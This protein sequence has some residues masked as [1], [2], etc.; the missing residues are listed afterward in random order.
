MRVVITG[1][2]GFLGR[3]VAEAFVQQGCEVAAIVRHTSRTGPLE[4]LGVRLHTVTFDQPEALMQ[5]VTGAEAIVHAAAKVH[6]Y[7]RWREFQHVTVEGT[8]ALLNAVAR[9]RV[10]HFI[11]LSTVGVYGWPRPDGRPFDETCIFGKP[12]RWNY[13]SRAKILAEQFVQQSPTPFT[14]LRPTWVY[15]PQDT[16]SIPRIVNA[17]RAGRLKLIGDGN[18]R[19]SIVYVTD[20]ARAVVAIA[21]NPKTRGAIFNIANDETCPTQREFLQIIC[22]LTGL[23]EPTAQISYAAAHRLAFLS[24]GVAH[25]TGYR[26]CPPLTRLAVLLLGGQRRYSSDKI[27]RAIGWQTSIGAEEGLRCALNNE[28]RSQTVLR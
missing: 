4:A 18:N 22:R 14:I 19:L 16:A 21:Q 6:T 11:H 7:G 3:H 25:V 13:Y 12:Y 20:V 26:I 24:E 23:E 10:P 5:A 9:A 1:A 2:T 8:R 17:L 28:R 15:G 27:R